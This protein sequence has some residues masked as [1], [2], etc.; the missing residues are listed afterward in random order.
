MRSLALVVWVTLFF[1]SS[2]LANYSQSKHW[3]YSQSYED[4]I[5]V[6]LLLIFTGDYVAIV[7]ATF[8]KR[9]YEALLNYQ[10][11][12]GFQPDG[13]LDDQ[14]FGQLM[15]DGGSVMEK[16]GFEFRD[17]P[18]T[19]VTLGIPENL[20]S[21]IE[22]TKRGMRWTAKDQLIE[23]ETLRIPHYDTGY[24]QLFER[25]SREN[26]NRSVEYKLYRN[27]YF[28]VSGTTRDKDFYLR[29]FRTE[30]DT[31]GFSLS[32][33]TEISALMDRVAVAMSNSLTFFDG[34]QT[35]N[36]P[37]QP[38]TAYSNLDAPSS[39]SQ[40]K[41]T[42]SSGSG[43]FVSEKGHIGTN[44]HV[45]ENCSRL[46]VT[47]FGLARVIK[48]DELNDLAIVRIS[49]GAI[50]S[51]AKFRPLPVRRGEAV[52]VLGFP[53]SSILGNSLTISEGIVSSPS[54]I[55]G[56]VRHFSLS[57]PVQPGNS[58]GPVLDASGSVIGTVVAKLDAMKTLEVAGSLPENV[59]FAVQGNMM[60]TLMA[61][62]NIEPT[63]A[64]DAEEKSSA[65]VASLAEQFTVQI[66]CHPS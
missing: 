56:D 35:A 53:F 55:G 30:R 4:R 47:G 44:Y 25:L 16:V 64:V 7:D 40:P 66:V 20:F 1:S 19:G 8:G 42:S 24:R 43:Y 6:Q 54:G 49:S 5:A 60:A 22:P 31:R 50:A 29:A 58:G 34:S 28:I 10:Y 32:W 26:R 2:A 13:V 45:I 14:E 41:Q 3:F 15:A 39:K 48:Q 65:A 61:S 37:R 38:D 62:A 23:L 59:N 46:E 12:K 52:Y 18:K 11:R 63:Y 17:E 51:H 27:D 57:A 33:N 21:A 36:R 9:T